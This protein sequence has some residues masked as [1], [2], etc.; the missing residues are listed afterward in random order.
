MLNVVPLELMTRRTI[1][2]LAVLAILSVLMLPI[3]S[4]FELGLSV[5]LAPTPAAVAV[6]T[7]GVLVLAVVSLT[8]LALHVRRLS[9][10][11]LSRARYPGIHILK[12]VIAGLKPA[13]WRGR[14]PAAPGLALRALILL[15]LALS[16]P[17]S[18]RALTHLPLL[19]MPSAGL[20][21]LRIGLAPRV[22]I[23]V[24]HVTPP[25][26]SGRSQQHPVYLVGHWPDTG[27]VPAPGRSRSLTLSPLQR[28]TG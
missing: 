27:I 24:I 8:V 20:I 25:G 10:F 9:R 1:G 11:V 7:I 22:V 28:W 16:G 13:P 21:R 18:V 12:S 19:R 14:H 3:L 17:R 26:Y 23:S 15:V 4:L 2:P 6:V 5:L